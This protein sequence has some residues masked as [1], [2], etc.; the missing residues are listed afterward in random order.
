M[1]F[2]PVVPKL[3]FD[4]GNSVLLKTRMFLEELFFFRSVGRQVLGSKG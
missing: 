3:Y 2:P 4:L 1:V